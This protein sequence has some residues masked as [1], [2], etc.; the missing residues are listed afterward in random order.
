MHI[1]F[2]FILAPLTM[3][4]ASMQKSPSPPCHSFA[5]R[6]FIRFRFAW[7]LLRTDGSSNHVILVGLILDKVVIGNGILYKSV[8][9]GLCYSKESI[10]GR[11]L[12]E[13]N[14]GV[15]YSSVKGSV[16]L[17]SDL[18]ITL[19]RVP[20]YKAIEE[21]SLAAGASLKPVAI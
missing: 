17:E 7:I 3:Y 12:S 6:S 13:V 5:E 9:A 20:H 21:H 11:I 14:S 4:I 19:R 16:A 8:S 10:V 1:F 2:I 15:G 18:L